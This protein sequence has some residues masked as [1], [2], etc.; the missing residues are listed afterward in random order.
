MELFNQINKYRILI[1]GILYILTIGFATYYN[2]ENPIQILSSPNAIFYII[3]VISF[4]FIMIVNKIFPYKYTKP[5]RIIEEIHESIS[6]DSVAFVIR[7]FNNQ[8]V[9]A[10]LSDD[11]NKK[12]IDSDVW[13]WTV[14][15]DDHNNKKDLITDSFVNNLNDSYFLNK[16]IINTSSLIFFENYPFGR[17]NIFI[18]GNILASSEFLSPVHFPKFPTDR[19]QDYSYKLSFNGYYECKYFPKK[20]K[21]KI[22]KCKMT[23]RPKLIEKNWEKIVNI[24]LNNSKDVTSLYWKNEKPDEKKIEKFLSKIEVID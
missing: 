9:V 6:K 23:K 20:E 15:G 19:K 18:T 13:D 14:F 2:K 17:K 5:N 1:L 16:E 22:R 3:I 7:I 4:P 21:N 10:N 11:F 24:Y 8:H 12:I